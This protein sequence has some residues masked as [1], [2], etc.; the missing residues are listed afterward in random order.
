MHLRR[1]SCAGAIRPGNNENYE[2]SLTVDFHFPA[3][4][5]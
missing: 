4:E 3:E 1:E 5:S 2:Y